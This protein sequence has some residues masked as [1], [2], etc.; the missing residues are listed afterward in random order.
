[1]AALTQNHD[2]ELRVYGHVAC[3]REIKDHGNGM[4]TL[5]L[6]HDVA[7]GADGVGEITEIVTLDANAGYVT[8]DAGWGAYFREFVI[9]RPKP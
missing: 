4:F 5:T 9:E 8:G 3:V 2:V 7:Q 1:M 6:S